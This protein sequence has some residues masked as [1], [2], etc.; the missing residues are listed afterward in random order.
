VGLQ[1]LRRR[2]TRASVRN[3]TLP[4]AG[5]ASTTEAIALWRKLAGA[6]PETFLPNLAASLCDLGLFHSKLGAREAALASTGE[7]VALWR[8]LRRATPDAY[9]LNLAQSLTNLAAQQG[10]LWQ[11]EQAVASAEEALD[12][13]WPCFLATP[14]AFMQH[15]KIVLHSVYVHLKSLG[16]QP[17]REFMERVAI[18]K[19]WSERSGGA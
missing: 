4:P 16:R 11:W 2:R 5:F 3:W 13:L 17:R 6:Q 15:T 9:A 10:E 12:I 19:D 1:K 18:F 14:A 7:S 8:E